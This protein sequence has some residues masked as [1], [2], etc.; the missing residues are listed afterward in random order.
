MNGCAGSVWVR[1]GFEKRQILSRGFYEGRVGAKDIQSG[2]LVEG[3]RGAPARKCIEGRCWAELAVEVDRDCVD[4]R[5]S[6]TSAV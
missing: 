5:C 4:F 6:G 2:K 1:W 3:T